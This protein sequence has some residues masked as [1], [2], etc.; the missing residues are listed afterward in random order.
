MDRST[1]PRD[2]RWHDNVDEIQRIVVSAVNKYAQARRKSELFTDLGNARRLVRTHGDDVRYVPAWRSWLTWDGHWRRDDDGAIIRLAK[3]CVE[4]MFSEAG[5]INDESKRNA[6]RAHAL[7]S[8]SAQRL[9]A[10]VKLAESEIEVILPAE[11]IDADPHFSASRTA[12]SICR[13]ASFEKQ[14]EK[15]M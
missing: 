13:P 14:G 9:A 11:Q 8:Q 3:A 1:G 6:M 2:K 12:S 4:E 15:T 7:R 5:L 10:M